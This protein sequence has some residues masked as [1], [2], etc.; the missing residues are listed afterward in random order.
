MRSRLSALRNKEVKIMENKFVSQNSEL[1]YLTPDN[2]KFSV[3]PNGFV[4]ASFDGSE[5]MNR[6]YLSRVFPHDLPDAFI[7][8]TDKDSNEYG[9][10][11]SLSDFDEATA[12]IL[13]ADLERKYFSAKILKILVVEEKFGNS[14]WTV[15]TPQGIRVMTLR[16]TFKSIIRIGDDRAI[17]VDENANRYEIESLSALDRNSFRRIELF[18]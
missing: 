2:S 3:T 7:S 18:L 8:V 1:K 14:V 16:D 5:E 13:R 10:I 11:K 12:A 15:E 17:V 9:I 4:I 6:V